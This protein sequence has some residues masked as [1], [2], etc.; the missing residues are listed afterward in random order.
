MDNHPILSTPPG[1]LIQLHEAK[2]H[3]RKYHTHSTNPWLILETG[4]TMMSSCWGW[5]APELAS[6]ANVLTYDRA[7]LG[8]SKPSSRPR[9][10]KQLA[11]ELRDLLLATK[12]NFPCFF[13]GHSMGAFIHRA[14]L[15][16]FPGELSGLI[17]IDPAHPDQMNRNLSLRARMKAFFVTLEAASFF[18]SRNLPRMEQPFLQLIH[19]LPEKDFKAARF[20]FRHPAHLRTCVAEARVW[21]ESA[22][23]V[24]DVRADS[25]PLL[26]ISAQKRSMKGW[27][28]LQEELKALSARSRHITLTDASHA[29]LLSHPEHAARVA[30]EVRTFLLSLSDKHS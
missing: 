3:F 14:W 15:K 10:A 18:A 28:T 22:D 20:F 27:N 8:W 4:L 29:S 11:I 24:R 25:L 7:G 13:V 9:T 5:L 19:G 21:R 1:D 30:A 2:I 17:W 23:F 26:L 6:F 16:L 12:V